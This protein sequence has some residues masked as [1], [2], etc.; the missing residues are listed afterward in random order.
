MLSRVDVEFDIA[1]ARFKAYPVAIDFNFGDFDFSIDFD[2]DCSVL[3]AEFQNQNRRQRCSEKREPQG[4]RDPPL[5]GSPS[6]TRTSGGSFFR[7]QAILIDD[8]SQAIRDHRC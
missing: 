8:R 7:N 1:L 3:G 5:S 4:N 2:N 6:E